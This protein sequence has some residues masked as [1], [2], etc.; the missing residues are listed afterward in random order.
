M[1]GAEELNHGLPAGGK[2]ANGINSLQ[3]RRLT[4]AYLGNSFINSEVTAHIFSA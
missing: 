1:N 2:H 4:F 3:I